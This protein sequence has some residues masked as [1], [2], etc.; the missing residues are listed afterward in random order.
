[1]ADEIEEHFLARQT[2]LAFHRTR[3]RF[4]LARSVFASAGIDPGSLL[5][6]RYLQSLPLAGGERV[7]DLGC[8]HGTLG[9]TL[10]ALDPS[11]R[12]VSVDRDALALRYTSR[13]LALN[14]L[15]A[16]RHR[17]LGS[18]GYDAL[19]R[20]RALGSP[21]A[22][23]ADHADDG[24][25]DLIV[26]NIPGKAGEAVIAELIGRAC[27][28]GHPGT[29]I[30][31]VVV[32]PLREQVTALVEDLGLECV[33]RKGNKHHEVFILRAADGV[34]ERPPT[35]APAFAAGV[36][37]RHQQRFMAG[38]LT[39][40]ATTVVGLDEFD[41]LSYATR[42]LRT[43]L[44]GI[45]SGPSLVVEPGQGHRAVIAAIAG[46]PPS[47]LL[48]RDRLAL[49]A[50]NR[51][52]VTAGADEPEL[53]HDLTVEAVPGFDGGSPPPVVIFHAP[54]KVH[55][56]WLVDQIEHIIATFRASDHGRPCDLVLI[57]RAGPLGRLESDVLARR[58]GHVAHKR[59]ERG[60]RALRFR[61][62]PAAHGAAGA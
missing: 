11:R 60:F 42:L 27:A 5:L 14:E 15:P 61:V 13:N 8:G 39:W 57:G 23:D 33:L 18:L 4:D 21:E 6:L 35:S 24:R 48:S 17:I 37:D 22:A 38:S 47:A 34:D 40:D 52:L 58:S 12:I 7:L 31:I 41:S 36:Y 28:F 49:E 16:D 46:Y 29:T 43:A 44:Q 10:Q 19:P 2:E 1:M 32:T 25:F 50:S 53:V 20:P 26:S 59:S 9:L 54:E 56:P 51:M 62:T 55:G 45:A 3:L 30:G